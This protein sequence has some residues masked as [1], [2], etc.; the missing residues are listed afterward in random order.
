MILLRRKIARQWQVVS[1][2][3]CVCAVMTITII[4]YDEIPFTKL[5]LDCKT[6]RGS[7]TL[8]VCDYLNRSSLCQNLIHT[9]LRFEYLFYLDP[10]T[11]IL[12]RVGT[13]KAKNQN[14]LGIAGPIR[15]AEAHRQ[16]LYLKL[17][18]FGI[19]PL[20]SAKCIKHTALM[21]IVMHVV[22]SIVIFLSRLSFRFA[23]CI[24]LCKSWKLV[25]DF[26]SFGTILMLTLVF[27][28]QRLRSARSEDG[29]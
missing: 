12:T 7:I 23:F 29:G 3:L 17:H 5:E 11:Q 13:V 22:N 19:F 6:V 4:Y 2:D 18:I 9:I 16:S 20:H 14:Q 24:C 1:S 10:Q 26:F 15:R 8:I 25:R 28:F 21:K 27:V